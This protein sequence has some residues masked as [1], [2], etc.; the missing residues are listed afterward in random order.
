[1]ESLLRKVN[2]SFLI[3][4][5]FPSLECHWTSRCSFVFKIEVVF[6]SQFYSKYFSS[7]HLY[8]TCLILGT[9]HS[10]VSILEGSVYLIHFAVTP[11]ALWQYFAHFIGEDMKVQ[12]AT[13]WFIAS[14]RCSWGLSGTVV[15]FCSFCLLLVFCKTGSYFVVLA[16]WLPST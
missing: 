5:W 7:W 15:Y 11:P 8:V 10:A 2:F 12:L 16:G 13:H 4:T 1:M 14:S 9:D 3:P 6:C